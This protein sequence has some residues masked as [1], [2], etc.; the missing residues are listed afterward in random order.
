MLFL[1]FAISVQHRHYHLCLCYFEL[2]SVL[3]STF[4]NMIRVISTCQKILLAPLMRDLNTQLS[5]LL[6]S[7]SPLPW[8]Y[9]NLNYC[10]FMTSC[11]ISSHIS[12]RVLL[13]MFSLPHQ[14]ML[15]IACSKLPP[16]S[17]FRTKYQINIHENIFNAFG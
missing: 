8:T 9:I 5:P 3:P 6:S 11:D 17:S 1:S 13:R 7:Y 16:S 12:M 4:C 2:L 10:I 15:H 14:L